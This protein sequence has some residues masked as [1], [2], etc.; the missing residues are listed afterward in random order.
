MQKGPKTSSPNTQARTALD[1]S[2]SEKAIANS[3]KLE[4]MLGES[5]SSLSGPKVPATGEEVVVA[6]R[7]RRSSRK[8][9]AINSDSIKD[10]GSE[11]MAQAG[12]ITRLKIK[13]AGHAWILKFDP[14]NSAE[15]YFHD[16]REA[17]WLRIKQDQNRFN[18]LK[19]AFGDVQ[20]PKKELLLYYI[21]S[22]KDEIELSNEADLLLCLEECA[23]KACASFSVVR[24]PSP[25]T[26]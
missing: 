13:A 12:Q 3:S 11:S 17:A 10:F 6:Q 4:K 2:I 1:D 8:S 25:L 21:D 14:Y 16:I 26:N 18:D 15:G 19:E 23:G 9:S 7:P 22:E 20:D 24:L 5:I